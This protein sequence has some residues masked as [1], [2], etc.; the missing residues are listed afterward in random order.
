LVEEWLLADSSAS[1][2]AIKRVKYAKAIISISKR[3]FKYW[4]SLDP[5]VQVIRLLG[6]SL[7]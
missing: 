4:Q 2:P 6:F 7:L 5:V 3:P 1:R